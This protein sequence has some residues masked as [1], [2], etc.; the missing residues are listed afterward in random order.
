MCSQLRTFFKSVSVKPP[1]RYANWDP[2]G[3]RSI[4]RMVGLHFIGLGG[5]KTQPSFTKNTQA[6]MWRLFGRSQAVC[7]EFLPTVSWTGCSLGRDQGFAT[8]PS[9]VAERPLFQSSAPSPSP[10]SLPGCIYCN[11][12][13]FPPVLT[14]R[15]SPLGL[16]VEED[17][18]CRQMR[19]KWLG[20]GGGGMG[21]E[22]PSPQ[23]P[24][25]EDS[26]E[27]MY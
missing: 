4:T 19:L 24:S 26:L 17:V 9:P 22:A 18:T 10:P 15:K 3:P 20:G 7:S 21:C 23:R 12:K 5:G 14:S 27:A 25:L 1:Q 8:G 11:L 6:A 13:G 2:E 16:V